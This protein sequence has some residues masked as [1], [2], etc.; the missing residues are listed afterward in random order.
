MGMTGKMI[1]ADG[2]RIQN[3]TGPAPREPHIARCRKIDQ[4]FR[5][6]RRRAEPETAGIGLKV[7]RGGCDAEGRIVEEGDAA[8]GMGHGL[9]PG[10]H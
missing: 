6:R 5:K 4:A 9:Q 8:I 1:G 3:D 2:R 10:P 7:V